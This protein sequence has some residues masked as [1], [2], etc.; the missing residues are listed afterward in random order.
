[1]R[2]NDSNDVCEPLHPRSTLY[3]RRLSPRQPTTP[4]SSPPRPPAPP[5]R[6]PNLSSSTPISSSFSFPSFSLS[7]SSFITYATTY[8]TSSTHVPLPLLPISLLLF[9]VYV[10]GILVKWSG[11]SFY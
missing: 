1:M 9:V 7:N 5:R 11:F 10:S 2:G 3:R 6:P 4:P 8:S